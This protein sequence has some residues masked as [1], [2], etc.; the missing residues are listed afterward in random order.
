MSKYNVVDSLSY[1]ENFCYELLHSE[2]EL[3]EV[4]TQA[5]KRDEL[6]DHIRMLSDYMKFIIGKKI[7]DEIKE[8]EGEGGKKI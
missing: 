3:L 4:G 7:K 5:F 6:N 8:S 1:L 2:S